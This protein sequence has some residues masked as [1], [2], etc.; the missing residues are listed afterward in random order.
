MALISMT[1]PLQYMFPVIPLLPQSMP[2]SEQ[3]LLAPTP[4]VIG[5]PS[6]FFEVK[7]NFRFPTDV[8]KVDLDT[9]KAS[10]D[11]SFKAVSLTS[12]GF[13]RDKTA[14][15]HPGLMYQTSNF[16]WRSERCAAALSLIMPLWCG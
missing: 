14:V 6:S 4:Y 12:V 3:L 9:N 2:G 1:Y 15:L 5:V 8:W 11:F 10:V 13:H 16:S 7:K